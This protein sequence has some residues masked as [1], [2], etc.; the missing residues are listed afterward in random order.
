MKSRQV[1]QTFIDYFKK[2]GHREVA[3]SSIV[4]ENDATLL[5]A[6]AGMNQFKNQFLG[7]EQRDYTRA[8]TSQKCVR[9]GGKHNDL[10]EVGH[11]TYHHT[12]FEMLGNWSFGDYFKKILQASMMFKVVEVKKLKSTVLLSSKGE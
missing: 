9:A 8:V 4:P 11:D 2:H 12:L 1:R 3:S 7:L 6:N 5:F 10:E